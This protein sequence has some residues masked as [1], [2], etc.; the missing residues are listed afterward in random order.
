MFLILLLVHLECLLVSSGQLSCEE[1]SAA[2]SHVVGG[3]DSV[4]HAAG[5]RRAGST[6]RREPQSAGDPAGARGEPADVGERQRGAGEVWHHP[7]VA[8]EYR[9]RAE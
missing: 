7:P 6:E 5:D 1:I 2:C 3:G 8:G 4:Q 9:A